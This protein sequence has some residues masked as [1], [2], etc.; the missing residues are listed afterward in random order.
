MVTAKVKRRK[1]PSTDDQPV[2]VETITFSVSCTPDDKAMIERRLKSLVVLDRSAYI[3]ALVR[4][5]CRHPREFTIV[6][7]DQV[8]SSEPPAPQKGTV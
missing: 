7:R 2:R 4:Q 8:L 5:D 6:P 3:I 1:T